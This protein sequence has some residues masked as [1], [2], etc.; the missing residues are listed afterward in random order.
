MLE[1]TIERK[2]KLGVKFFGEEF[3]TQDRTIEYSKYKHMPHPIYKSITNSPDNY[4]RRVINQK[5]LLEKNGQL[6]EKSF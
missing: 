3:K 2:S 4:V 5:T 6:V 1:Q